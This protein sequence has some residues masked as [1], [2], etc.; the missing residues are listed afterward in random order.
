[1]HID[2]AV[3]LEGS[4]DR[5]AGGER[6]AEAVNKHVHL[7]ALVVGKCP[8]NG[9]AV[10]VLASDIAFE[11]DVVCCLGHGCDV[12]HRKLTAINKEGK[13]QKN[14]ADNNRVHSFDM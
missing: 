9:V 7:L 3:I 12:L 5:Q 10:E 6:A 2:I 1:M 8:V 13:R 11:S 4:G 14:A